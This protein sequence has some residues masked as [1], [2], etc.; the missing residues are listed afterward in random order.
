MADRV[1]QHPSFSFSLR[2]IAR[3][4][5]SIAPNDGP[6]SV[7]A[8]KSVTTVAVTTIARSALS[9]AVLKGSAAA[10]AIKFTGSILGFA[11]FALAARS[12]ET[13][14]FGTLAIVFNAMSFLAVIAACGQETLIVRSWD[15]YCGS[16]RPAL[17]RGA[18]QFGVRVTVVSAF[19][20]T[21]A[22]AIGWAL[23]RPSTP[24]S[25][26]LSACAF[27]L[28][29]A[30]MNFSAQFSRVARGLVFGD[31]PR[32]ILWRLG[33]VLIIMLHRHSDA[34]FAASEFFA[35]AAAALAFSIF[36]QQILMV[37]SLP[38][39]IR[40]AKAQYDVASWLPRSLHMWIAAILE[41]SSQYLEVIVVGLFLGPTTA[42]FFFVATR[43]TNVFAMISSSITGY[44]TTRISG[45]FHGNAKAELQAVLR[46]LAIISGAL[47]AAVF[48]VIAFGGKLLLWVFGSVYVSA[49]PAL[50]VLAAGAFAGALAG[51]VSYLLLLTGNEGAYPRI[52]A[53][54][55][56][57]RVVLIA[58]LGPW[59]GLM[60]AAIA[61]SVSAIGVALALVIACRGR[62]G[63]DPSVF[64]ILT[65]MR[66]ARPELRGSLS[67]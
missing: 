38:P 2:R 3:N 23:I 44:A 24:F 5:A 16:G 61:W 56:F 47:A 58:I 62:T 37:R 27:L 55:L 53:C 34:P 52:M 42:A 7:K 11:M 54:G 35:T 49:Y 12:M 66:S 60:G 20:V 4:V 10:L 32:E 39:A 64:S 67:S 57:A 43:I 21:A 9:N 6:G 48:I 14:D 46:S 29:Q 33:V 40:Q 51:P 8:I 15:E 19:L 59:F 13:N 22:V 18:L 17:A 28:L 26:L 31:T 36:L 41:T 65:R 50:L 1:Y 63:V 30:F 25:L 45:L